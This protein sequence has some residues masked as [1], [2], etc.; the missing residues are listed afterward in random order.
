MQRRIDELRFLFS[1]AALARLVRSFTRDDLFGHAAELSFYAL[2]ALFPFLLLTSAAAS[3]F[4]S[5][6]AE[7]MGRLFVMMH[8]FMPA[9]TAIVFGKFFEG[10]VREF[11][12]VLMSVGLALL[13]WAVASGLAAL[14]KAL[15]I[16]NCTRDPRAWWKSRVLAVGLVFPAVSLFLVMLAVMTGPD[17]DVLLP[18][19]VYVPHAA[20]VMWNWLRWPA[21]AIVVSI[22]LSRVYALAPCATRRRARWVST[23][24]V[25]A[26]MIG[27]LASWGLSIYA[28]RMAAYAQTYGSVGDLMLLLLWIH[29]GAMG[30]LL[31][32]EIDMLIAAEDGERVR[33]RGHSPRSKW[34]PVNGPDVAPRPNPYERFHRN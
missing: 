24:S 2:F 4:L 19:T 28:D 3:A 21:L 15:A 30:I 12:P 27:S 34:I 18:K 1:R 8:R 6:P 11:R 7:M 14:L 5:N 22:A 9:G 16:V 20:A 10:P 26:A 13:V 33:H 31:G 25:A 29:A 32:A 23:G 17:L